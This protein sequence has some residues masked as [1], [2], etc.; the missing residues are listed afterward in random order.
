MI[1]C[2]LD[3][4]TPKWR[5]FAELERDAYAPLAGKNSR[6]I[7]H[8]PNTAAI[9]A[10]LGLVATPASSRI[11]ET[12]SD[13]T[14]AQN[15]QSYQEKERDNE[16]RR[17]HDLVT[18]LALPDWQFPYLLQH[19]ELTADE[20]P[21]MVQALQRA[22]E[23]TTVTRHG[24]E[25]SAL[26][27]NNNNIRFVLSDMIVRL[28]ED[29]YAPLVPQLV[30]AA[31]ADAK[32][33]ESGVGW[34]LQSQA[35]A[36]MIN[37]AMRRPQRWRICLRRHCRQNTHRVMRKRRQCADCAGQGPT[38]RPRS[39]M[40]CCACLRPPVA[41]TADRCICTQHFM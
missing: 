13:S 22:E 24:R 23:V 16:L 29:A 17:F 7:D 26:K 39:K 6:D 2:A 27:Y 20:A 37:S 3:S 9:A 30:E 25:H 32:N 11:S 38:M 36:F 21:A 28:P 14:V 35:P 1:G 41:T 34:S 19:P 5:C 4:A 40:T 15:L 18:D 8:N 31:R 10:S 12:T 33:T